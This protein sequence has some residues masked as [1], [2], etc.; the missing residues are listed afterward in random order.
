MTMP[1]SLLPDSPPPQRRP[2][3]RTVGAGV[4]ALRRVAS[5]EAQQR[6]LIFRAR[7][8]P[9]AAA[10]GLANAAECWIDY[11]AADTGAPVRLHACW[12]GQARAEAPV[13]LYLHGAR[14]HLGDNHD[15]LQHL[16][17]LG[18]AVLGI[19]YR[20]F[21]H[22]T[23]SSPSERSA[24]EDAHAAWQWL[25]QRHPQARRFVYGHSLGGA[26]AVQL[27]AGGSQVSGLI[28]EG[29]FTSI[30]EVYDTFKWHW[31]PLRRLITQHFDSARHVA[32]VTAPILVVHGSAD[33]L[34]P[35]QLGRALFERATSA[36]RFVLVEGGSHHDTHRVGLPQVR[37]AMRELF[38]LES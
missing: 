28:V 36:K 16:H 15:R 12:L 25:A 11:L 34:V 19:D 13:L 23:A 22:S 17:H 1:S 3:H 6:R 2:W 8:A 30:P 37:E 32:T 10:F 18:F 26:V 20:G 27:A 33:H 29:T 38:G 24:C 21:G 14:C 7:R 35:P 4:A 5:L 31:L 9:P